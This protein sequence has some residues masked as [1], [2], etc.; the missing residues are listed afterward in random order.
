MRRLVADNASR[1]AVISSLPAVGGSV[2]MRHVRRAPKRSFISFRRIARPYMLRIFPRQFFAHFRVEALPEAREV[3]GGLDRTLAG[4][5][6]FDYHRD[7]T[8]RD[9]GCCGHS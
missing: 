8:A 7:R 3:G 1:A 9:H 6:E 5:E 4:G 2:K